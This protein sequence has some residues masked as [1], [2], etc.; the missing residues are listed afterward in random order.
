MTVTVE[1]AFDNV[2][3]GDGSTVTLTLSG[4]A[5]EGGSSTVAATASSGV[6]T[7]SNLKIDMP[8]SY[9]LSATDGR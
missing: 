3:S 4:G 8:G 6:A 5:F 9:T 2:V 7:F 1:D